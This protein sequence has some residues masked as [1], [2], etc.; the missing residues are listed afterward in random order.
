MYINIQWVIIRIILLEEN[1]ELEK[2]DVEQSD[3]KAEKKNEDNLDEVISA[4]ESK[5]TQNLIVIDDIPK[6][7]ND[8]YGILPSEKGG[9]G[10]LMWGSTNSFIAK[11]LLERTNFSTES[12]TLFKLTS[13]ALMSR[14]QKPIEKNLEGLKGVLNDDSELRYLKAKIRILSDLIIHPINSLVKILSSPL[15]I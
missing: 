1:L 4:A 10:W 9:L 5:E 7:F 14:A 3:K 6:E 2:V 12:P 11:N 13:K 15:S 8:W